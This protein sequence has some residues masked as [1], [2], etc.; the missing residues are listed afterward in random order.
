[1]AE[2]R[3]VN[4][5]GELMGDSRGVKRPVARVAEGQVGFL[6]G[7]VQ[8]FPSVL[9]GMAVLT[10]HVYQQGGYFNPPAAVFGLGLFYLNN[11]TALGQGFRH[12]DEAVLKVDILP[13]QG[14][15]LSFCALIDTIFNIVVLH[16]A[17]YSVP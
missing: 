2:A 15:E 10:Q 3:L 17:C 16:K 12:R 5:F 7:P 9:L 14:T 8:K 4:Y 1:M 13:G 11:T 6:Q